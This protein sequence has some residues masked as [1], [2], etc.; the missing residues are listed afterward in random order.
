MILQMKIYCDN[1]FHIRIESEQMV[2]KEKLAYIAKTL[3]LKILRDDPFH[4]HI[5]SERTLTKK[6]L[7]QIISILNQEAEQKTMQEASPDKATLR[8]E[9]EG[10][11]Q[12]LKDVSSVTDKIHADYDAWIRDRASIHALRDVPE[13]LEHAISANNAFA[14][15]EHIYVE[16][17]HTEHTVAACETV[18]HTDFGEEVRGPGTDVLNAIYAVNMNLNNIRMKMEPIHELIKTKCEMVF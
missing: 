7:E 11:I 18:V 5:E 4:I 8:E 14:K 2:T 16:L 6:E 9:A 10:L 15:F 3:N 17:L 1:P 12:L 13:N